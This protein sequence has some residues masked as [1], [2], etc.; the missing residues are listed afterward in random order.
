MKFTW[1]TT[2]L[3]VSFALMS[4]IPS[5]TGTKAAFTER[6][7][8]SAH[9]PRSIVDIAVNTKKFSTLVAALKAADLVEALSASGPFTVFAPDNAAFDKL[10]EGTVS[11]LL[12][13]SNKAQLAKVLTY[14]V[15][16]GRFNA[17]DVLNAIEEGGG[18]FEIKTLGGDVL[19]AT[20][21][22][23]TLILTDESG[24]RVA[25]KKADVKASNGVIHIIDSVLLPK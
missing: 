10:P 16:S 21:S 7:Y 11:N 6:T 22:G 4:F 13:S 17:S 1:I 8:H 5:N 2:A 25:V 3:A 19:A 20:K 14:H 15:L 23:N 12:K 24:Q 9:G 18:K